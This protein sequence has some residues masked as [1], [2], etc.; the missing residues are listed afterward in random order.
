MSTIDE[1]DAG[2]RRLR[3]FID[4]AIS[5][6]LISVKD[7]DTLNTAELRIVAI[8]RG[9]EVAEGAQRQH[10]RRSLLTLRNRRITLQREKDAADKAAAIQAAADLERAAAETEARRVAEQ[11]VVDALRADEQAAAVREAAA[12]D[13][14]LAAALADEHS[15]ARAA[16]A[17]DMAAATKG[18][19][20][21]PTGDSSPTRRTNIGRDPDEDIAS[22]HGSRRSTDPP[23]SKS[24]RPPRVITTP[25][26]FRGLNVSE[27]VDNQ[28][29]DLGLDST[30]PAFVTY[31][32]LTRLLDERDTDLKNLISAKF[33]SVMGA[34]NGLRPTSNIDSTSEGAR[35]NLANDIN[36]GASLPPPGQSVLWRGTQVFPG[37]VLP[38]DTRPAG[39]FAGDDNDDAGLN[40]DTAGDREQSTAKNPY[41]NNRVTGTSPLR[42]NKRG[43]A[44]AIYLCGTRGV[45]NSDPNELL[46]E[47]FL[48]TLGFPMNLHA[49]IVDRFRDL[50]TDWERPDVNP[51]YVTTSFRKLD[52][53]FSPES[54]VD[55]YTHF[56]YDLQRYDICLMPFDAIV[57]RWSYVGLCLPGV[58]EIRYTAM[59]QALFSILDKVLPSNNHAVSDCIVSLLGFR[60]DGYRLLHLVMTRTLPVFCP[61]KPSSPYLCGMIPRMFPRWQSSG[62]SISDSTSRRV[63]TS[64][65][66]NVAFSSLIL[67][68]ITRWLEFLPASKEVSNPSAT[69]LK[70][71]RVSHHF[72]NISPSMAWYRPLLPPSLP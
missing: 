45:F 38:D 56:V 23:P 52:T 39:T 51:K 16:I 47:D 3:P 9:L 35:R 17:R 59:G 24:V 19:S 31:S 66:L 18:D 41:L 58:G 67:S 15:A 29:R 22:A 72:L 70:N 26:A 68:R 11:A 63:R 53:T 32:S 71:L 10:I 50:V 28:V 64:V 21:P 55:W 7:I 25:S 42:D 49:D 13:E 14:L 33:D 34:I 6:H 60:H 8:A 43:Q 1:I 4:P 48:T 37:G 5:L 54:F 61:S 57:L 62:I 27:I 46:V 40:G 65:P 36:Q 2:N 44:N 69:V 30:P 20:S 12:A